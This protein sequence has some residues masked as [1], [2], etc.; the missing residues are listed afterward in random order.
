[1]A[2]ILYKTL[3]RYVSFVIFASNEGKE[4]KLCFPSAKNNGFHAKNLL[5]I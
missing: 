4:G 5:Y 3:Q 1:M 2:V